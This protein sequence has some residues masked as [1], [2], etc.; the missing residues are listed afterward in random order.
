MSTLNVIQFY[1]HSS[2]LIWALDIKTGCLVMELKTIW[3]AY[4]CVLGIKLRYIQIV[5]QRIFVTVINPCHCLHFYFPNRLMHVGRLLSGSCMVY[6]AK[7]RQ[8]VS[9]GQ[10][11]LLKKCKHW[12]INISTMFVN[13]LCKPC[14]LAGNGFNA[15]PRTCAPPAQTNIW[16]CVSKVCKQKEASGC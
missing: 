3:H 6:A 1:S 16:P 14:A 12:N 2:R 13:W 9:K 15:M 5:D 10:V 8:I 4:A 7:D 11:Y